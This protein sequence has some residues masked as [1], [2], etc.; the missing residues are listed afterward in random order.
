MAKFALACP[1]CGTVNKASTF[2]LAKKAITC[3]N[4]KNE[5]DV[6]ANRMA[7][8]NC[9]KCGSVA[10][11]QAK[12]TCPVCKGKIIMSDVAKATSVEDLKK[13]SSTPLFLCPECGC[14]IQA[15]K[16]GNDLLCPV[17]DH[18]FDGYEDV[19]KQIQ[20]SKLVADNGISVIKYEGDNQ[21]FVW[22]HPIEDFNMG[23]QLIVHESQEAVFFLNGQALDLF[24]PGRHT[25]ETENLPVLKKI[26]DLPTGKQNP[27][28]AEVYFINK[29]VQMGIKWGTDSRVRFIEPNTG[30]PLDI[31]ASGEMNLQVSD[32]RK[33]L[34]KLVGTTGGLSRSQILG[35]TLGNT[36]FPN[37]RE[38]TYDSKNVV[39]SNDN[40]RNIEQNKSN[41]GWASTLKGYFRPLI[42][43]TIKANLAAAIKNQNIDILEIDEQLENLSSDLRQKVSR[44][45][46]EYGL[47]VPQ[48]YVTNVAL[49]EEDKNFKKIRELRSAPYIGRKEAEVEAGL[50]AARRKKI[51]EEQT[52]ALELEK[53]EAE[54]KRIAAQAKADAMTLEGTAINELRRQKGLND[55]E[56]M[57]AQGYTQKD[58]LQA[59]VQEAYAKGIGQMGSNAGSAGGSMMSDVLGLGVGMAAMGA[60]GEKVGDVMKGFNGGMSSSN[61]QLNQQTVALGWKCSCGC[62]GNTG[63]FCSECGK[64]KPEL[65]ECPACGAKDNKGKFCSE[66]G[67]AKPELWDCP[68]CGAKGNK[69]KFCSECGKTKE[70]PATWDCECGNK[71][72]SGKFC[73]EC[74]KKKEDNE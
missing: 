46:E 28:H 53:F 50:V 52:T 13:S 39:N 58:V 11:D 8:G 4:C 41:D 20:K 18:K 19:F 54:K 3:G 15:S 23:S 72:I 44:G 43:T 22:K 24:G 69:G 73:S 1:H 64:A 63:K 9:E 5:I 40:S 27:F 7:V 17:C 51:L 2:I 61:A 31:G 71:G 32:S 33:L 49:P 21:T 47:F 37:E 59:R 38:V 16:Q 48:F 55:A 25:L 30:I 35:A 57:S 6:K 26:C 10:F 65:W 14:D 34:I 68:H 67:A 70:A 45:F 56:V 42:M 12:G 74:G 60:M 36:H 29:T 66:C 62:E